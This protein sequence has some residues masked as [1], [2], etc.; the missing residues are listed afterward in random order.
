[1]LGF[2]RKTVLLNA[3]YGR[4]GRCPATAEGYTILLPYPA[5]MPFLLRFALEGLRHL[6]LTH[7]RQI[8]VVGDGM[9]GDAAE[10]AAL[11]AAADDP[12]IEV[13]GLGPIDRLVVGQLGGVGSSLHW[14]AI[15]RGT[16]RATGR[17]I[18]LHDSDAFFLEAGGIE[19]Q[20]RE[21]VDRGLDTLGVT[22]RIDPLFRDA[23]YAIPGT[24][25][26]IYRTSWARS[27]APAAHKGRHQATPHGE[28]VFDTM[29]YPQYLDYP[30][31][32]VGV[33]ADPPRLVHFN[34]TIVTYRCYRGSPGLAIEDE[35]FRLLLLAMLEDLLPS[36]DGRRVLPEVA[37]L[38]RCLAGGPPAHVSYHFPG[39]GANYA[40][41]RR[42]V[43]ELCRS[44]IMV[45][46]RADRLLAA[47]RPFDDHFAALGGIS[48]DLS[49]AG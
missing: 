15:V 10:V 20:Y 34:G 31:G 41:F 14:L 24:W 12:R 49:L 46:S 18:F 33:M 48:A 4:W 5:D 39:A 25:E 45:G 7:C 1:M 27:H 35:F 8:L 38:V 47:I 26:M 42:L 9:G 16:A 2:D 11:V 3:L 13:V 36:A 37:E 40:T 17:A 43:G 29:L 30:R 21:L 22:A 32:R 6:D 19:R 44:P 23:G 28:H